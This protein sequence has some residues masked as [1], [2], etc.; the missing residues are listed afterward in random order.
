MCKQINLTVQFND[1]RSTRF[2]K[3]YFKFIRFVHSNWCFVKR[4]VQW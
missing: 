4:F 3:F 1:Y 2:F